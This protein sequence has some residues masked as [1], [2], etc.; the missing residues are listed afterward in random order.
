MAF[1]VM[2][3][4][5]ADKATMELLENVASGK[6]Q[7]DEARLGSILDAN[8][9][10]IQAMQRG[11]KLPE[12]DWGVEYDLGPGAPIAHL[13]KAR[14]LARL[15][16]L[17]GMR[18]AA[19]GQLPQA[20]DTWLTGVRFAQHVAQK[21]SLISLLTGRAA[22]RSNMGALSQAVA[23]ASLDQGQ[24]K[25]IE[26]VLRALPDTAFD[27]SDA[28]RREEAALE[29]A[30]QQLS[31]ARDPKGYYQTMTGQPAPGN[32]SLPTP[33]DLAAFRGLMARASDMLRLPPDSV[34][35]RLKELEAMENTLHPLFQRAIP[36]LSRINDV[37]AELLADRRNLLQAVAAPPL[38]R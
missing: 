13:A 20:V 24:R 22:L 25:R 6:A 21:G 14:V 19:R 37:R 9:D 18:L 5:P 11:T 7:W 27:W 32:F 29:V 26:P 12:C 17:A 2:Q 28:M 16:T 3:D 4:P 30:V 8:S 34:R 31:Q 10:A 23:G 15:N 38:K 33:S 35:Q 36:S 1:A